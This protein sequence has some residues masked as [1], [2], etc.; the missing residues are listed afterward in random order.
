MVMTVAMRESELDT[1]LA[2]LQMARGF[3]PQAQ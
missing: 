1:L 2:Y 3:E